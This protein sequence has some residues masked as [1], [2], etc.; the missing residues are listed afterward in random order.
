M[1]YTTGWGV[2]GALRD[3]PSSAI[4]LDAANIAS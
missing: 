2:W 4:R 3:P 1:T